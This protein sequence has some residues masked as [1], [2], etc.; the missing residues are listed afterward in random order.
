MENQKPLPFHIRPKAHACQHLVQ[1]KV[2]MF[3]RG[4]RD[5]DFV[6][7]VKRIARKTLCPKTLEQRVGEKL[8]L[9]AGLFR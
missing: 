4:H 3:G 8:R 5:E 6:G 7:V 1:E 9:W 2:D